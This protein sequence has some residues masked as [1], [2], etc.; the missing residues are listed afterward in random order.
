MIVTLF[1][2]PSSCYYFLRN[3]IRAIGIVLAVGLLLGNSGCEPQ[4]VKGQPRPISTQKP[5]FMSLDVDLVSA[6]QTDSTEIRG[7]D[8]IDFLHQDHFAVITM[9]TPNIL[10]TIRSFGE[11]ESEQLISWLHSQ[12]ARIV[13]NELAELEKIEKVWIIFDRDQIVINADSQQSATVLVIEYDSGIGSD[14]LKAIADKRSLSR[15]E[16]VELKLK[17]LSGNRLAIASEQQLG[18]LGDP[19]KLNME[20]IGMLQGTDSSSDIHG[21]LVIRPIRRSLESVLGLMARFGDS[22]QSLAQL[23]DVLQGGQCSLYLDHSKLFNVDLKF[24]RAEDAEQMMK[25]VIST[26]SSS[27]NANGLGMDWSSMLMP[28]E[29]ALASRSTNANSES[30]TAFIDFAAEIKEKDLLDYFQQEATISIQLK[31]PSTTKPLVKAVLA[32]ARQTFYLEARKE[33]LRQ[34]ASALQAYHKKYGVLPGSRSVHG[35]SQIPDQFSWRVAL[36]P[37]LGEQELYQRFNFAEPWDSPHNLMVA[38]SIPAV[39]SIANTVARESAKDIDD[40]SR[41]ENPTPSVPQSCLQIVEGATAVYRSDRVNPRMEEIEDDRTRTAIVIELGIEM[42]SAWTDPTPVSWEILEAGG[43][44]EVGIAG[45]AG[46]LLIDANFKPRHLI[47][48]RKHFS[49]ILSSERG[50]GISRSAFLSF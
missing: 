42:A 32:E 47:K 17:E 39:F 41:E 49:I 29:M 43:M 11:T 50:E 31:T 2:K 7:T 22:G 28:T 26:L 30:S 12:L 36:L 27:N 46:I 1:L 14:H 33:Q 10:K 38:Q 5:D 44:D 23:P 35:D 9:K 37:F 34:V 15:S 25:L 13:G 24:N 8:K 20:L 6:E 45:A 18:K 19:A 40:D 21:A 3:A 48:D 4:N 16:S